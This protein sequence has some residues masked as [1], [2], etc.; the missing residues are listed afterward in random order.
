M[1]RFFKWRQSIIRRMRKMTKY[2][3]LN[4]LDQLLSG[5][6][7]NERKE[8][9]EDYEE[10]FAFAKR[11]DKSDE[12]VIALMGTP[13]EIA[14]ELLGNKGVENQATESV[15]DNEHQKEALE[16][17]ARALAEQA[18]TL[19]AKLA[20]QAKI[21]EE[22]AEALEAKLEAEQEVTK[23][24]DD[25]FVEDFIDQ[26]GS[27]VETVVGGAGVLV[28][29]I[30]ETIS[31]A[32]PKEAPVHGVESDTLIEEIIDVT[33]VKN[34][35]IKARNQKIDIE[36]TTHK[37]ARVRLTKGMLA[38]H[39]EGDTLHIEAREMKRKLSIG[40][41]INFEVP[42]LKVELPE[43]IYDVIQAKTTNA[44]IEIESFDLNELTLESTNAKLEVSTL[45]ANELKLKTTNAK[46]QV[47]NTKGNINAKTT[48][49]KID[50]KAIDGTI[51]AHSTNAKI[52]LADITGP[53]TAKT[54]NGKV[55]LDN[56]TINQQVKLETVNAK[57]EVGV[58]QQPKH[59]TFELS[60]SHA[61]TELFGTKRNYDVF[62][63]GTHEV[64]LS[65]AN[66]KI[67]VYQKV[68]EAAKK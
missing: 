65:T 40:L 38:T 27:F 47:A 7:T 50:L 58:L 37:T 16:A 44:K 23:S 4:E 55:Q 53:I 31:G 67:E 43:L 30:S 39:V 33:G 1:A 3:F 25:T 13:T 26:A 10:H 15:S 5:L 57:I 19:E 61:K 62:G 64:T 46:I 66:A 51:T 29:N 49:G 12:E 6:D 52:E 9:L 36:K 41:F 45:H 34:V 18:K 68:N 21:L 56:E 59:A 22:Q 32:L 28:G 17:Q 54:S 48:N 2:S 63:E 14:Q 35:I 20:A 11:A 42:E 24:K 8:I 60:T